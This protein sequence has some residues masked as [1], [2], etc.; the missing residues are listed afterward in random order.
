MS[1]VAAILGDGTVFVNETMEEAQE[2][3]RGTAEQWLIDAWISTY[4]AIRDGEEAGLTT[5]VERILGRPGV[6]FQAWLA[7]QRAH[8]RR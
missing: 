3:R 7:D 4:T 1:D 5:D 8:D 2:S 6:T